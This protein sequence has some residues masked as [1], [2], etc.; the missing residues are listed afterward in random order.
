MTVDA[1]KAAITITVGTGS[2]R[3]TLKLNIGHSAQAVVK[4]LPIAGRVAYYTSV[5]RTPMMGIA[6]GGRV[7]VR[8]CK[9][10]DGQSVVSA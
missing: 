9:G 7:S 5:Y 3:K 4:M 10:R 1:N 2:N 6:G 8:R